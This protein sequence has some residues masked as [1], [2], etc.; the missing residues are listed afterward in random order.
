MLYLAA[1]NT[2]CWRLRRAGFA[3][4]WMQSP[5]NVRR[6]IHYQTAEVMPCAYDNGLYHPYGEPPK[7]ES[8]RLLIYGT[9]ARV[10]AD[11]WPIPL[12]AVV[13]D[14]PYDGEA[15]RKVSRWHLPR[16]RDLF[17]GVPLAVAVQDGMTP[18]DL[19]GFDVCA[20]AGSTDWKRSTVCMWAKESRSRGMKTHMLRVNTQD[21]M[22]LAKDAG[23]DWAD[24]TGIW[25]GDKKQK[26]GLLLAL[27]QLHLPYTGAA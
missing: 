12:F 11:K 15:S 19:D 1:N 8:E 17:P 25:R 5:R 21:R 10:L 9:L 24:G 27:S 2:G 3:I 23:C 14:V 20:V 13:P 16:M 26:Q 18:D 4:G 22:Q 6:P 7:P